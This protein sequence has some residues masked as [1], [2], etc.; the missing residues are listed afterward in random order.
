[1][2]LYGG[3]SASTQKTFFASKKSQYVHGGLYAPIKHCR[4]YARSKQYE[5]IR[6]NEIGLVSWEFAMCPPREARNEHEQATQTIIQA[7]HVPATRIHG[8]DTSKQLNKH[9]KLHIYDKK[10]EDSCTPSA[11]TTTANEFHREHSIPPQNQYDCVR[12]RS[13]QKRIPMQITYFFNLIS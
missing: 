11:S 3:Q 7:M 5:N 1:M 9:D 2:R 8:W 4:R 12:G 13:I 10:F 6:F